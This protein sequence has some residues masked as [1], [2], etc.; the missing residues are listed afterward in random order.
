MLEIFLPKVNTHYY[1]LEHHTFEADFSFDADSVDSSDSLETNEVDIRKSFPETWIYDSY[2]DI[3]Y[4]FII[5][6][7]SYL[8]I[9]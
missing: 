8:S 6:F 3:G 5:I 7:I 9:I 2:S 1:A 4:E